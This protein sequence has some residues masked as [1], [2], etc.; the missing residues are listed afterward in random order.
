MDGSVVFLGLMQL[1]NYKYTVSNRG[2]VFRFHCHIYGI[3]YADSA[4]PKIRG[5]ACEIYTLGLSI[6]TLPN[7][8]PGNVNERY[9]NANNLAVS[10]F[11]SYQ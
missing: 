6:H 3:Q 7:H 8:V 5:K 4:H 2:L 10:T 1:S 9:M 11:S